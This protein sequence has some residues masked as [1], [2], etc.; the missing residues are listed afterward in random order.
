M[1][2]F[3]PPSKVTVIVETDQHDYLVDSLESLLEQTHRPAEIL[4]SPRNPDAEVVRAI[5]PYLR[6]VTI[7]EP[8]QNRVRTPYVAIMPS[9]QWFAATALEALETVLDL[10]PDLAAVHAERW[11]L[12]GQDAPIR[13]RTVPRFGK[14]DALDSH[15]IL[16]PAALFRII[17]GTRFETSMRATWNHLARFSGTCFGIPHPLGFCRVPSLADQEFSAWDSTFSMVS[18][19]SPA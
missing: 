9:R 5:K 15:T 12:S 2:R 1:I 18:G 14:H 17:P 10:H 6:F 8:L 11:E 4:V 3:S 19:C 16:S 13:T 7:V